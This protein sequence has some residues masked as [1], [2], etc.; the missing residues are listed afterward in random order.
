MNKLILT[1]AILA[2]ATVAGSVKAADNFY[3]GAGAGRSGTLHL[4][5][6]NGTQK[7][8]NHPIPVRLFGGYNFTDNVAIEAGYKDFGKYK[9]DLPASSDIDGYYLAAKGS[10]RVGESWSLFGKAGVSHVN[11]DT[12]GPSFGKF[13]SNRA[14]FGIGADYSITPN[15]ALGLELINYGRRKSDKGTLGLGQVEATVRYSF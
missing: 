14:M 3:L 1:T 4:D 6:P 13:D 2:A 12:T 9:F 10:M 15:L 8:T 11:V 7:N 5:G